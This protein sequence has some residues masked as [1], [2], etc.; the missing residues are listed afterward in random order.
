[1]T[2]SG[3]RIVRAEFV[4]YTDSERDSTEPVL[5]LARD[6][7]RAYFDGSL[8]TFELPLEP[9]GSEFAKSVWR[10]AVSIGYG[11]IRTYGEIAAAVGSPQAAIAVG[12]AN[13]ANPIA[14]IIP[15]HRVIGAGGDLRGYAYGL[16]LKR[17]LLDFE[18]ARSFS[19]NSTRTQQ[20]F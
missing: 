6:Q 8:R 14:L 18:G 3:D 7:I 15:C 13:G 17:R 1:M 4:R 19:R 20:L 9:A 11:E 5:R 16:D 2:A 12:A 10:E